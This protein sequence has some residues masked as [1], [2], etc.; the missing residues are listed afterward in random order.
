MQ[1]RDISLDRLKGIGII[2]VV[3]GHC[4][5]NESI[6][7]YIYSFHMPLFFLITG[8][9][10]SGRLNLPFKKFVIKKFKSIVVPYTFLFLL[11]VFAGFL[12][13]LCIVKDFSWGEGRIN[14]LDLIKAWGLSGGYLNVYPLNNFPLWYLP[15]LFIA[16]IC[17]YWIVKIKNEKLLT[18]ILIVWLPI[19]ILLSKYFTSS[20]APAFHINALPVS[21]SYLLIGYLLGIKKKLT[22][23]KPNIFITL[24]LLSIG[25]IFAFIFRGHVAKVT[26][27]GYYVN[28]LVSVGGW[29]C[30]A[31]SSNSIILQFLGENSLYIFGI[32]QLI[33]TILH[34]IGLDNILRNLN[35]N[36]LSLYVIELFLILVIS[37]TVVW[38]YLKIKK[39]IYTY[40][41]RRV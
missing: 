28:S 11:S 29:Y 40:K 16:S 18:V 33:K 6:W 25:Y 1:E 39:T 4:I 13:H 31:K 5:S 14:F 20:F 17:L 10:N 35:Q 21:I 8:Y 7:T 22:Y 19:S 9:C 12:T 2:F 24:V 41:R 26:S 30:V 23:I 34:G 32:H 27:L 38:C 3:L 15:H 36:G 37:S